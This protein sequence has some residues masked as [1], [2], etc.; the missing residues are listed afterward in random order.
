MD[1]FDKMVLESRLNMCGICG[2]NWQDED[3]IPG[4]FLK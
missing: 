4:Y 2:F 1:I 3:L